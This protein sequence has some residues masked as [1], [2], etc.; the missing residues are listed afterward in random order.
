M[1][2]TPSDTALDSGPQRVPRLR[3]TRTRKWVVALATLV[4]AIGFANLAR[5]G[6]AIAYALRLPELPM[7]V[8]W[9]YLAA[10]GLSWG[11][12]LAVC[13]FSL[14]SFYR[15][16]RVAT[17]A[18]ATA[19]QTHVWVTHLLYDANE[20][21]RRTWPRDLVLSAL[22][23]GVVWAVLSWPSIRREFADGVVP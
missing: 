13:S 19:F 5:G 15:W 3:L 11:L 14:A 1:R 12:V 8:R 16:A 10:T 22:F 6:L 4:L 20:Y 18:A 2:R 23:L 9:E 17:L 21:A 7:T